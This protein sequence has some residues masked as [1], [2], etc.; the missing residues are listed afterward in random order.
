MAWAAEGAGVN[1]PGDELALLGLLGFLAALALLL[2]R[3]LRRERLALQT[4]QA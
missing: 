4:G 2:V 3:L 1:W